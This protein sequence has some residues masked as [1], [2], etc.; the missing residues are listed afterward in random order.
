MA[1]NVQ[2]MAYYGNTPWHGLGKKIEERATSE[3]MIKDAGLDWVVEKRPARGATVYPNGKSNRYEIVRVRRPEVDEEE[4]LFGVVSER[5]EPLQNHEAFDFFD[6]IIAGNKACFETAGALGDGERIW[7]LAKMPGVMEIVP[8]DECRKYLLLSNSHDGGG[9]V[10]IK[11]TSIRVV[12]QNT[13]ML[14]LKNGQKAYVVRHTKR[15]SDRLQEVAGILTAATEVYERTAE[16]FKRLAAIRLN[17]KLR[18]QYLEAVFPRTPKQKQENATPQKWAH[19]ENM[20]ETSEDLQ[21]PKVKGTMW[22]LYNAVTGFEDYKQVNKDER[23]DQRLNRAWFGSS[24]DIKLA[25]LNQAELI[26]VNV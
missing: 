20:L 26:A 15:M 10:N 6:P 19:I 8:G 23:T 11:F 12:C 25:A 7:A 22:A 13:L 14:A 4:V 16:L 18:D 21:I 5:Y 24:A 2:T 1:H 9:A 17:S 3:E